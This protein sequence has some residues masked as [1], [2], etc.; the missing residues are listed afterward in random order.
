MPKKRANEPVYVPVADCVQPLHPTTDDWH[1]S[2]DA[3]EDG[4]GG[5]VRSLVSYEQLSLSFWGNDDTYMK[6]FFDSEEELRRFVCHLPVIITM[7][8]LRSRGFVM[9]L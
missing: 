4:C 5:F 9:C 7:E 2:F 1:L 3:P 6:R 8:W